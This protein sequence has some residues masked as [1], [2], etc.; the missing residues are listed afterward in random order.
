MEVDH[1]YLQQ[2]VGT[3]F[4]KNHKYKNSCKSNLNQSGLK[5]VGHR[6]RCY[7][8]GEHRCYVPGEHRWYVSREH[9]FRRKLQL[10]LHVTWDHFDQSRCGILRRDVTIEIVNILHCI[11]LQMSLL[12]SSSAQQIAPS[13]AGNIVTF[14]TSSSQQQLLQVLNNWLI[15]FIHL[16]IY[17]FNILQTTIYSS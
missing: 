10:L 11:C 7:V 6:P 5:I 17:S 4:I 16:F 12:S 15:L 9:K 14:Q 13:T 1:I 2:E 3:L 8:P